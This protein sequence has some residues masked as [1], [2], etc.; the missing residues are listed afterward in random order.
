MT[1]RMSNSEEFKKVPS[2]E[3]RKMAAIKKGLPESASWGD[4][5]ELSSGEARKMAAIKKGLPKDTS[6]EE[7][8]KTK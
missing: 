6:W 5:N 1:E 3:A 4:I 8:N 7:I 2:E